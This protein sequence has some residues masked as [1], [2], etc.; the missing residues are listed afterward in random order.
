MNEKIEVNVIGKIISVDTDEQENAIK[1]L[2][3]GD[4]NSLVELCRKYFKTLGT[5]PKMD[6]EDDK[7]VVGVVQFKD[8]ETR[9]YA[10]FEQAF[11]VVNNWPLEDLDPTIYIHRAKG[12]YGDRWVEASQFH[13][14]A[15]D[16][17]E[18]SRCRA[19]SVGK[20]NYQLVLKPKPLLLSRTCTN[21]LHTKTIKE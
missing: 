3:E 20:D 12:K 11:D 14:Q 17:K 21:C 2:F 5:V 18:L 13:L 10:T 4:V 15:V 1:A 8:L 7:L 6:T 19:V 9:R 16:D